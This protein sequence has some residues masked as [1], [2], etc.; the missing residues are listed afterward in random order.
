MLWESYVALINEHGFEEAQNRMANYLVAGY[1]LTPVAP[2][3]TE[4]RDAI[5]AAA[6]AV[7][8]NDYKLILGAFAK[9]GMGLGAQAPDRFSEDLTGV[10]ESD[11]MQLASFTLKDVEMNASYNG[12]ELVIVRNDNI[13]DKGETGT[14]TV[15]MNT[16]S[17]VLT[18]TQAQLT[19]VSGH[20]V[21]FENDGLITFDDT[22]P[23]ASQTSAPIKFTLNDAGTADTLENRSVIP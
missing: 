9:R 2:L 11:K 7:D 18:G 3:Y 4:A 13:L 22:T 17:E 23:Y 12:V 15:S 8:T 1:K 14:L 6:Y 19:V 16:G 5:L 20:D 10:V 21:T